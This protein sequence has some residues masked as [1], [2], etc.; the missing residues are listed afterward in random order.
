MN[1]PETVNVLENLSE[2]VEEQIKLAEKKFAT[3]DAIVKDINNEELKQRYEALTKEEKQLQEKVIKL[4]N[5]L[6][7]K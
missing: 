3:A 5:E 7:G 1:L 4:E 6:L 2:L